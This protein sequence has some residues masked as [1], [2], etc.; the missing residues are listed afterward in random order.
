MA[1]RGMIGAKGTAQPWRAPQKILRHTRQLSPYV[2]DAPESRPG[3]KYGVTVN[4]S[5]SR[6][7]RVYY[8]WW[9]NLPSAKYSSCA[10]LPP[11]TY[12]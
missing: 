11:S 1:I 8:K 4:T 3:I 10:A 2:N 9:V 5:L 7:L 6:V 12:L